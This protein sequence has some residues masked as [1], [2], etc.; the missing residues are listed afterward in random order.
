MKY[1]DYLCNI[2]VSGWFTLALRLILGTLFFFTG[3]NKMPQPENF[4][5]T[6]AAF[7]LLPQVLI[8]PVAIIIP[9]IECLAGLGLFLGFQTR[10]SAYICLSLLCLFSIALG[11][12][13]G[14]EIG[15]ISCGCFGIG[16]GDTLSTALMR[17]VVLIAI[18]LPLLRTRRH[19]S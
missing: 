12:A 10:L 2:G 11:I 18:C 17:N 8:L 9:Y 14:R 3:F 16:T 4:A 7:N 5:R 6:I 15:T 1:N 19:H 13:I